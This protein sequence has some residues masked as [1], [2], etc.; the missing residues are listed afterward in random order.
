[1]TVYEKMDRVYWQ[2]RAK[3]DQLG[4]TKVPFFICDEMPDI[5]AKHQIISL[6]RKLG[7]KTDSQG[8]MRLKVLPPELNSDGEKL[9]AWF[10]GKVYEVYLHCAHVK[11]GYFSAK[12][13]RRMLTLGFYTGSQ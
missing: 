10:P 2:I 5:A 1:M 6:A 9:L 13:S 12:D 8:T 7:L 3:M 4:C 11:Q